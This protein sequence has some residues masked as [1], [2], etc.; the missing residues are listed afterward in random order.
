ML[1][2]RMFAPTRSIPQSADL[3]FVSLASAVTPRQPTSP[4]PITFTTAPA[5]LDALIASG[6]NIVNVGHNHIMDAGKPGLKDTLD[7]LSAQRA[8]LPPGKI[9]VWGGAGFTAEEVNRVQ[10]F[11]VPGKNVRVAFLSY[12]NIYSP[13]V[14]LFEAKKAAAEISGLR[15]NPAVDLILVSV[16]WG[17]E[18]KHFP[19][20]KVIAELRSLVDAG[21]DVV[22]A[23]QAHV[24]QGIEYY[25]GKPI[26]YSLG[27]YL[28]GTVTR[29]NGAAKMYG[30]LP[31][32][33]FR[34]ERGKLRAEK[35]EIFPTYNDN[36]QPMYVGKEKL[37]YRRFV[38]EVVKDPFAGVILTAIVQWSRLLPGNTAQF[39]L[40]G[41][42]LEIL[43]N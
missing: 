40:Q 28:M 17:E 33:H 21:A 42:K 7:L 25:R 32:I 37:A 9:L 43:P 2:E 11:A 34:S 14:N 18:Y 29:R 24:P 38:T 15:Q 22:L 5:T 12:G 39:A 1:G 16:R 31:K 20:D 26:F 19:G 6:F 35:I 10:F 41:E 8:K 27:N 3:A 36:R 30:Y 4:N 23:H 13:H